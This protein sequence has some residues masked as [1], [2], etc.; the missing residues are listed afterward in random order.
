MQAMILAAG[1]GTRVRPLTN[2][3]PKPMIPILNK[4]IMEYLVDHLASHDIRDIMVNTSYMASA[5]EDYFRDG[6]RFGV[7][8]AYSFEGRLEH[9]QIVDAPVGSA[10]A[11]RRIQEHAGF[12]NDTFVVLCGDALIDV[13]LTELVRLHK[14]S[15]AMATIAATSVPMNEVMHYGVIVSDANGRVKSFQE[16]PSRSEALSNIVNT[17]IYIFEPEVIAHIPAGENYD[18]GSQLFPALLESGVHIQTAE[19]NFQWLDIGRTDDYFNTVQDILRGHVKNM[20]IPGRQ[21]AP[22]VWAGLNVSI[23]LSQV[24]IVPPLYIGSSSTIEEGCTLIGPIYIGSGCHVETNAHVEKSVLFDYTRIGFCAN[25][26]DKMI[27]GDYC[28]DSS[29]DSINIADSDIGWVIADA[30]VPKGPLSTQQ[31]Q[32]Q[33]MLDELSKSQEQ[34]PQ[35]I[36]I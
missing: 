33:Q 17:G 9:G 20:P 32:L 6:A 1:R 4:P 35:S 16:K 7:N 5:I 10:G 29:G 11:I 2:A 3:L 36:A 24:N 15:G 14:E 18:I 13:D 12:F 26:N 27:C 28:V 19:M 22:G 34:V 21:I 31:L 25:I 30:R 8:M 23:D